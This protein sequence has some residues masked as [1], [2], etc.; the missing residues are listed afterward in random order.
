MII[1]KIKTAIGLLWKKC[2]TD[3][4]PKKTFDHYLK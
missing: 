4:L 3:R 2:H 1:R